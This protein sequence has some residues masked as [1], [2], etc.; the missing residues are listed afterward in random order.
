MYPTEISSNPIYLWS[1]ESQSER[2]GP[3]TSEER[4]VV[5]RQFNLI[6]SSRGVFL[7]TK[8]KKRNYRSLGQGFLPYFP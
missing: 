4:V 8:R 1:A 7:I 6:Q 2:M 5:D 3:G